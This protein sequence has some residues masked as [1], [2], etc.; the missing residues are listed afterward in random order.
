M[1]HAVRSVEGLEKGRVMM[2]VRAEPEGSGLYHRVSCVWQGR[3]LFDLAIDRV[4]RTVG[5]FTCFIEREWVVRQ[6]VRLSTGS[7]GQ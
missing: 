1:P 7:W 2:E 5:Y 3:T 6:S 4:D